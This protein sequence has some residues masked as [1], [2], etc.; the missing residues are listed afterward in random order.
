MS[1]INY[2][3]RTRIE[4]ALK[5]R[6]YLLEATRIDSENWFFRV[7][8]SVGVIYDVSIAKELK[9]S[10]PDFKRK[11]TICKH[12][13]FILI[14]IFKLTAPLNPKTNIFI[15]GI[16][17]KFTEILKNRLIKEDI[18]E[19]I[20]EISGKNCAICY[21]DYQENIDIG[22]KVIKCQRCSNVF[23]NECMNIWLKK[24]STCPLCRVLWFGS[25]GSSEK[26]NNEFQK[27]L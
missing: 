12:I 15:P 10:C 21:E 18:P 5:Q 4:R 17:K 2:D 26:P 9:C 6:M 14:R 16:D 1:I 24:G 11:D 7:E 13:Y 3:V 27:F 25:F 20:I 8:G 19:N 22:S 23:H